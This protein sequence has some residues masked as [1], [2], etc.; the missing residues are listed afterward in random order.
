M[1]HCLDGGDLNIICMKR[2]SSNKQLQ[3]LNILRDFVK[4]SQDV[5]QGRGCQIRIYF[6]FMFKLRSF[7]RVACVLVVSSKLVVDSVSVS[8]S[9]LIWKH[10]KYDVF[11]YKS[12]NALMVN[13]EAIRRVVSSLISTLLSVIMFWLSMCKVWNLSLRWP[14]V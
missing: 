9:P 1:V 11:D 4:I 5:H 10:H 13:I 14:N 6:S 7:I 12:L 2:H 3:L 8:F